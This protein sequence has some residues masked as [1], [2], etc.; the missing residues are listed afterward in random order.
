MKS[1][2]DG[3]KQPP[4]RRTDHA[5]DPYL[6]DF[7]YQNL[8]DGFQYF[9]TDLDL[10]IRNRA[11]DLMLVEVKRKNADPPIHQR[12]TLAILDKLIRAGLKQFPG[13]RIPVDG[14]TVNVSYHGCHLLQFENTTAEDGRVYWDREEVNFSQL[15][16]R[17]SFGDPD[18][19]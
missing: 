5:P 16:D 9:V 14:W 12:V 2:N 17:L 1:K 19:V 7:F 6:Y 15:I 10:V 13:G 11:G 4:G 18:P 8:P 3:K